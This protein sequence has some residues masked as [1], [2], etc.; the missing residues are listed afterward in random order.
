VHNTLQ[1]V[2]P[3]GLNIVCQFLCHQLENS[4]HG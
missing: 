2:L 4:I 1:G 3:R